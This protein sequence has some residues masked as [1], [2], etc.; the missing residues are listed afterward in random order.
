MN[1]LYYKIIPR[2][3]LPVVSPSRLY[4]LYVGK[5]V[6]KTS[7]DLGQTTRPGLGIQMESSGWVWTKSPPTLQQPPTVF[8]ST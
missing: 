4:Y 5:T 2:V 7:P 8:R 1:D 6:R 3:P